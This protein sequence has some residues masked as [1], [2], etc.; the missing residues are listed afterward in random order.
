MLACSVSSEGGAPSLSVVKHPKLEAQYVECVLRVIPELLAVEGLDLSDI[1]L[2]I[3]PQ[4]SAGS[5]DNLSA[6]LKVDRARFVDVTGGGED[7]FTSSVPY[8]LEAVR[9]RGLAQP[10]DAGLIIT[11]GAGIEVGCAIYYF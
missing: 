11:A 9:C 8:A 2:F 1:A 3:P 10:G 7:L 6:E 4:L 5:I